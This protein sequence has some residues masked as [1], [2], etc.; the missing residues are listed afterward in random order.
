MEEKGRRDWESGKDQVR[1]ALAQNRIRC[2][3]YAPEGVTGDSSSKYTQLSTN[4]I[5]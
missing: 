1:T 5:N 2:K 4:T 3:P